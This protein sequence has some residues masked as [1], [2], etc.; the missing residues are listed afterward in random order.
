MWRGHLQQA[1]HAGTKGNGGSGDNAFT[2]TAHVIAS[3]ADKSQRSECAV[4]TPGCSL[5]TQ[6]KEGAAEQRG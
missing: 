6:E 2:H 1:E 3:A 4:F 5:Q